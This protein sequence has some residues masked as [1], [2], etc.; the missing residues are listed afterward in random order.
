M[1]IG[2][3]GGGAGMFG[4]R[5]GGGRKRAVGRMGG[6]KASESAV[7]AAL[8]WFKK[9]QSPDGSWRA[10]DYFQNCTDDGPK[11]EPG[12]NHRNGENENAGLT[13]LALLCFL[14]A[15]YDHQTPNKYK[16][17]VKKGID[18]LLAHQQPNG[19]FMDAYTYEQAI[20]TMALAEAY[21]MTGDAALK[22]PAQ[23]AVDVILARR[24]PLPE[25]H[26]FRSEDGQPIRGLGWGDY[27]ETEGT[28]HASACGWS[29][30][31]LK[32]AHSAGLDVKDG[33]RGARVWLRHA[34]RASCRLQNID[35]ARLDPYRDTTTLAYYWDCKSDQARSIGE[36]NQIHNL[37]AIALLTGVFL[38]IPGGDPLLETTANHVMRYDLPAQG[39]G[40]LYYTYYATFGIFQIGG[41][42]WQHWN[43]I[44]RERFVSAQRK[45]PG[46]FDGSWDYIGNKH[47][48]L[49]VG[50]LLSTALACLSLEVYYRYA[51]T[52]VHEAGKLR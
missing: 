41:A 43:G 35:I 4:S 13:G 48:G 52:Q 5:T 6:S 14:G 18:W 11:C 42:R 34:W 51:Q 19:L 28:A 49:D 50:R 32:S 45:D 3:G 22:Q 21:A 24:M 26:A 25:N 8:R 2:A 1:A 36:P 40:N 47:Y 15:G 12:K 30:Q 20:A 23:R 31:A 46:C 37:A 16:Q 44:M 10:S 29:I 27:R 38:G 33:L 7:E 9:H 39:L 17:V